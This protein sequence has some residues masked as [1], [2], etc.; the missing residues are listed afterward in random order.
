MTTKRNRRKEAE[1]LEADDDDAVADDPASADDTAG[2]TPEPDA[3]ADD[4]APAGDSPEP[5]AGGD[6]PEPD[7]EPGGDDAGDGDGLGTE[8]GQEEQDGDGEDSS[9]DSLG[10]FANLDIRS[11]FCFGYSRPASRCWLC[12]AEQAR[13]VGWKSVDVKELEASLAQDVDR[14]YMAIARLKV[15]NIDDDMEYEVKF[16]NNKSLWSV[17]IFESPDADMTIE[18]RADF[19]KSE[20]FKKIAKTTWRRVKEAKQT[21]DEVVRQHLDEGELLLVDD[22]KLDAIMS[23]LRQEHFL[24][25]ILEG[26]YLDY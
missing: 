18:E 5:D 19:F 3:G 21:F 26:K 11:A 10:V 9:E 25:N 24:D 12:I 7:A 16:D 15:A 8:G 23:F 6:M 2:D 14:S 4:S 20:M 1:L 22:I 13:D 17:E